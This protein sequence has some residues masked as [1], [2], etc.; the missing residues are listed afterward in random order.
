MFFDKCTYFYNEYGYDYLSKIDRSI[1][2]L[3]S[4]VQF[5]IIFYKYITL[6]Y[7]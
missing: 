1:N 2:N 5:F 7:L 3:K 6:G 4:T